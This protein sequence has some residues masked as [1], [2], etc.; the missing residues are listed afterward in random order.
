VLRTLLLV[1]AFSNDDAKEASAHPLLRA[2]AWLILCQ[3]R[4]LVTTAREYALGVS[5]ELERRR[6]LQEEPDNVARQLE[7]AAFF[8]LCRMQQTHLQ[9]AIRSAISVFSKA[10]NNGAAAKLARRLLELNPS[11]P[12]VITQVRLESSRREPKLTGKQAKQRIAA[13]ERNPR[14]A[15]EVAYDDSR[16]F[17]ICAA[18]YTPIYKG[19]PAARCPYTDAAY[20]TRFEG[21]LDSLMNLTVIG[22]PAAGLPAP[23]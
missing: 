19:T 1:P 15:V 8:S 4:E 10:N 21:K 14:N 12:K 13:A 23:P 6:V 18:T 16:E 2:A 9:L 7:L 22:A 17:E 3:W 5:I 11:D 20:Q